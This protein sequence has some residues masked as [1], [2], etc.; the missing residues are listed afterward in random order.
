MNIHLL[1]S[2]ELKVETY[3]NVLDIFNSSKGP[4]RFLACEKEILEFTADEEDRV[5]EQKEDFQKLKKIDSN[6]DEYSICY[7][8]AIEFPYV[9]KAK[10]WEQLFAECDA[11][12][13]KK[14]IAEKDIVVLLTDYGNDQNWFGGVSPSMKNFFIQ[15]SNW[16]HYFGNS[17]D[18]RYPIA[19]EVIIWVMRYYMFSNREDIYKSAH[20][21][22]IGCIMDF[23]GDKTQI[24]LKMRTADVCEDCMDK[25]IR[26]DVPVLYTRQFF[27]ILDGIQSVMTFRGRSK[28][29]L[30]ASK[31]KINVT[32]KKIFFTDLGNHELKLNPK[33][34]AVYLLFLNQSKDGIKK[35]ELINKRED[36]LN[37]YRKNTDISKETGN[38]VVDELID[39]TKNELNVVISRINKKIKNAVGDSLYDF[40]CIQGERGEKKFIKLDREL[41]DV[42]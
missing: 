20:K 3:R 21:I 32:Q 39:T 40:Y 22:P 26:Q 24:T 4:M 14:R 16:K 42:L 17:I 31:I 5:W 9:E 41:I 13:K 37:E 29:I 25:F 12:R 30:I 38:K 18:I 7:D 8:S 23:C 10:T 15:T 11:F 35:K 28:L 34:W 19:Y 27:D 2:P 36:L 6:S 33:E 1:R